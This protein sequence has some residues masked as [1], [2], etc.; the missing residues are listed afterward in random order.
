MLE[1]AGDSSGFGSVSGVSLRV[2]KDLAICDSSKVSTSIVLLCFCIVLSYD[3]KG[4]RFSY[5]F[6]SSTSSNISCNISRTSGVA[7]D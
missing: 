4:G 3:S 5:S 1:P 2:S 6:K 7:C